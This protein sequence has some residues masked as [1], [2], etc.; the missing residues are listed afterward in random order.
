MNKIMENIIKPSST[1]E[2]A[3]IPG[4]LLGKCS[5]AV[6]ALVL[7]G[8]EAKHGGYDEDCLIYVL[9]LPGQIEWSV[10]A[11][12]DGEHFPLW[13]RKIIELHV[14]EPGWESEEEE[15]E[16]IDL[17]VQDAYLFYLREKDVRLQADREKASKLGQFAEDEVWAAAEAGKFPPGMTAQHLAIAWYEPRKSSRYIH[18][19]R[20]HSALHLA[21]S[22]GHFPPG[23][24]FADLLV[25]K[26]KDCEDCVGWLFRQRGAVTFPA[27][28]TAHALAEVPN[29]RFGDYLNK[30]AYFG[31]LPPGT[32]AAELSKIK[33]LKITDD[34]FVRDLPNKNY[35]APLHFAIAN[36]KLLPGTTAKEL[37]LSTENAP[38]PWDV[39][40]HYFSTSWLSHHCVQNILACPELCE[41]LRPNENDKHRKICDELLAHPKLKQEQALRD[42]IALY[43][44]LCDKML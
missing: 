4:I 16:R 17:D 19:T 26:G 5:E 14:K 8:S 27:E 28:T 13:R 3:G 43:P 36:G 39:A 34:C 9:Q 21:A 37:K 11:V 42:Q 41:C 23:T 38:S 29:K 31:N 35:A 10:I 15:A 6:H 20:A 44:R 1:S 12:P 30:A 25:F 18:L 24:T 40:L 32:T 22:K 7:A 2:L 33:P